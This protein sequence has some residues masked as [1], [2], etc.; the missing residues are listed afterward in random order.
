MIRRFLIL[1]TALLAL[2]LLWKTLRGERSAPDAKLAR[3]VDRMCEIAGDH[4]DKPKKGVDKLFRYL[5]R[6]T[7]KIGG[8]LGALL[9]EIERIEDDAAHDRRAREAARLIHGAT[10]RCESTFQR[11][12]AAVERDP[13]AKARLERGVERLGRTLQILLG[14]AHHVAVPGLIAPRADHVH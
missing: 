1:A 4:V 10:A 3:H 9:V 2:A 14:N 12:F 8:E 6:N 11:F 7:E 13:E 5:G